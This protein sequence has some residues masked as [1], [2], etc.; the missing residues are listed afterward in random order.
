MGSRI[1]CKAESLG[2]ECRQAPNRGG[3]HVLLVFLLRSGW[4]PVG[5]EAPQCRQRHNGVGNVAFNAVNTLDNGGLVP[6][7]ESLIRKV[8]NELE[9]YDNVYYEVAGEPYVD[10]GP[11]CLLPDPQPAAARQHDLGRADDLEDSTVPGDSGFKH[12]TAWNVTGTI[13]GTSPAVGVF[14]FHSAPTNEVTTNLPVERPLDL[15]EV[16][17]QRTERRDIPHAGLAMDH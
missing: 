11:D 9:P 3:I 8:V 7:Q 12:M 6:Y 13:P 1:L 4:G 2:C 5:H 15:D 17:F 10:Q 16:D 14:N